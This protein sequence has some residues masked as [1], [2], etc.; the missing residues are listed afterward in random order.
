MWRIFDKTDGSGF[1]N[2][3]QQVQDAVKG[4]DDAAV[5]AASVA[6]FGHGE[7]SSALELAN[8]LWVSS[9]IFNS[10]ASKNTRRRLYLMTN[11]DAPCP[12]AQARARAVKRADDLQDA[13][14]WIEPF[15]FSPPPPAAFDLSGDSLWREL[16]SATA[17]YENPWLSRILSTSLI[18]FMRILRL[19][20]CSVRERYKGPPPKDGGVSDTTSSQVFGEDHSPSWMATSLIHSPGE[21]VERVRRK[22]H[23]KRVSL[24]P[25]KKLRKSI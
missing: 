11:D 6:D 25:Q 5:A 17:G 10:A 2:L 9:V 19:Q 13:R 7:T 1:G 4:D 22:A 18:G 15:F 14:V 12:D 8:V 20:V 21:A 23:R 16:V 3:S 24:L